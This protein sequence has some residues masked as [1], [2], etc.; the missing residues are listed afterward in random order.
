MNSHVDFYQTLNYKV[1]SNRRKRF[2]E[3]GTVYFKF[4][5]YNRL[6][7]I[8]YFIKCMFYRTFNV[9]LVPIDKHSNIFDKDY[10]SYVDNNIQDFNP[11]EFLF[12]GYLISNLTLFF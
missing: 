12:E 5:A 2:V 1:S 4:D 8:F 10:V 6:F 9:K 11:N 3:D 7:N